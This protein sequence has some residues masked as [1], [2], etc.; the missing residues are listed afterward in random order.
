MTFWTALCKTEGSHL[1]V[2]ASTVNGTEDNL[3]D[4]DTDADP[5]NAV[6]ILW[7]PERTISDDDMALCI[8]CYKHARCSDNEVPGANLT[9]FDVCTGRGCC[10]SSSIDTQYSSTSCLVEPNTTA[11]DGACSDCAIHNMCM[12]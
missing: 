8:C 6:D 5:N 3:F 2:R 12:S 4:D 7:G 1:S 9:M 11:D 10:Q